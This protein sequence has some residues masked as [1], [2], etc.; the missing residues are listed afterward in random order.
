MAR[1]KK[2]SRALNIRLAASIYED[3]EHFCEETGLS[4]TSAAEK[5]FEQYFQKY[6]K[7]EKEERNLFS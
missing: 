6:F 4:K 7:K 3:L 1:E 2:E 5:I